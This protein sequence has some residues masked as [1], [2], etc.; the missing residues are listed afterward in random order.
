MAKFKAT[1]VHAPPV[2]M[3]KK[4]TIEKVIRL[5][6][7][8]GK[9]GVGLLVF[10]EV[11]VP[12]YPGFIMAYPP[13][14]YLETIL[15]Y[16][17][18]SVAIFEPGSIET[19]KPKPSADLQLILD[20]CAKNN[21]N[22]VLGV[23]ERYAFSAE[24]LFN[25]QV[26][27]SSSGELLGVHRKLVPT[28]SERSVWAFGGGATLRC[29]NAP[30]PGGGTFRIG[31]LACGENMN[32]GARLALVDEGQQV[33]AASWP[34]QCA[35]AGLETS[36]TSIKLHAQ[37]HSSCAMCF[38][39]CAS[40]IVSQDELDWTRKKFGDQSILKQGSGWSGIV[41]PNGVV[42]AEDAGGLEE[43]MII[44]EID[45]GAIGGAKLMN[46]PAGHYRRPEVLNLEVRKESIWKDDDLVAGKRR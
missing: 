35:F 21:I 43:K 29:W 19:G 38:T 28:Y 44:A 3:N 17:A 27:I 23:S 4:A 36:W 7:D 8:A 22:V 46:D 16:A 11:F 6:N 25:S 13:L 42:L 24:T 33:H 14:A 41:D 34:G 20:A 5:I 9:Q 26:F 18:H 15:E 31:G 12:G 32:Y 10:P 30:T 37:G 45:L 39:V 1:A 2:F 40:S